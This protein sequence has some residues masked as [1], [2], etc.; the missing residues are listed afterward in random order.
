V[1][2]AELQ[3]GVPWWLKERLTTAVA[4]GGPVLVSPHWGP[5]MTTEPPPHV[6]SSA[7]ALVRDGASLVAGHSA[8]VFHGAAPPVLFDLGDFLDDYAVDRRLRNDLGLLW[9]VTFEGPHL[10]AV[11]AVPL[12]LRF[13]HTDL[14]V[15]DDAVWVRSRLRQACAA[16]GTEVSDGDRGLVLASRVRG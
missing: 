5:N 9:L 14:A 11:E 3:A 16:L 12:R 2:W 13:A 8:H 1:A 7:R 15:G 4:G 6:R 10:V